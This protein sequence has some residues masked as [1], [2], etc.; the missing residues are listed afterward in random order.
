MTGFQRVSP[1][2]QV[3]HIERTIEFY[4]D[5]LGFEV[6]AVWPEDKPTWCSLERGG[7]R[8]MFYTEEQRGPAPPPKVSGTIYID[9]DDAEA[10][11]NELANRVDLLWGPEVY[12]YGMLE[13]AIRD[14]NGFTISF[15]SP[16]KS[17]VEPEPT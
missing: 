16:A 9:V 7:V 13:F 8:F 4:R 14:V 10:L 12:H 17:G 5:I 1:M 15:G 2:L 3:Q 11:C 6:T